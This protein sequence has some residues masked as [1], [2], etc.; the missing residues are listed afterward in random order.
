M[1]KIIITLSIILLFVI[2]NNVMS[3]TNFMYNGVALSSTGGYLPSTSVDVRITIEN[4]SGG[5]YQET[6][7][8]VATDQFSGFIVQV[9]TG[10]TQTG[11]LGTIV[12]TP[13]TR[14]T[15]ETNYN[16]TGW[17]IS[18][19]AGISAVMTEQGTSINISNSTNG[20]LLYYDGTNWVAKNAVI[21]N[22]GGGQAVNNMQPFLVVNYCIA[23]SGIYPTR[24]ISDPFI[25]TIGIFAF[26]WA[27]RYWA[28]CDGQ[29]ISISQNT[30]LFS[31]IGTY[32]GG[33]GQTTFG[34]PD[35][36][37]R[38]P[39]H[40]GSGSG[41]TSRTLGESS[42]SETITI[43]TSNLPSHTHTIVYQ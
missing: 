26:D 20:D 35:L 21:Q 33:N 28:T 2:S 38:V 32:Y 25:G 14:I 5:Y 30:A 3:L 27:P 40:Q 39:I 23:L 18:N 41:L 29:L 24:N 15:A 7:V 34:L 31:L 22:T 37:G 12:V 43:T 6:H 1:K 17:I 42:G 36:R 4:T 10:G 9:G 8:A 13:T 16:N 19:N 11:N